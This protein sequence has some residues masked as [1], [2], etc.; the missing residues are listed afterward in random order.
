MKLCL[1]I[2][3]ENLPQ[4]R[5]ERRVSQRG[6]LNKKSITGSDAFNYFITERITSPVC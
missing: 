6:S 1:F 2:S 4:R 5:G 3:D